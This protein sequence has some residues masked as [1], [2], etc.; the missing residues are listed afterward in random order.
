MDDIRQYY[1]TLGLKSS[2]SKKDIE[3]AYRNLL[4]VWELGRLPNEPN[5]KKNAQE[6]IK[7]IDDAHEKLI[8]YLAQRSQMMDYAGFWRRF[9]ALIID[10]FV[11]AILISLIAVSLSH[12]PESIIVILVLI[13]TWLYWAGMESSIKQ[14]TLG[15]MALGIIVTDLNGDRLTFGRATGRLLGKFVSG[16]TLTIGYIIAGFTQKKQAL[17]DMIS[18][19]LVIK[20]A[21]STR[22]RLLIN[23]S[24]ITL[25][26]LSVSILAEYRNYQTKMEFERREAELKFNAWQEELR[27]KEQE[28]LRQKEIARLEEA[29]YWGDI[30]IQPLSNLIVKLRTSWR[31]GVMYY[32]FTAVPYNSSLSSFTISMLDRNNFTLLEFE[33]PI[34]SIVSFPIR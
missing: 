31:A 32:V 18:D 26:I 15:K 13:A 11:V 17:H 6:K 16:L 21:S 12:L 28:E 33:I 10:A 27:Q 4:K 20:T 5:L 25:I 3:E 2:A 8:L 22:K 24:V 34:T 19:T 14:A 29:K 9:F 1:S 7:E 30:T 23:A